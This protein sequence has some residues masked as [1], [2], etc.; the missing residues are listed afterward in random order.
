MIIVPPTGATTPAM[1]AAAAKAEKRV[2]EHLR[3]RGA[4][5]KGGATAYAPESAAAAR[6]LVRLLDRG[7]V[8]EAAEGRYWFDEKAY[9]TGVSA[10]RRAARIIVVVAAAVAALL[11]GVLLLMEK[12]G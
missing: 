7:A 2:V 8:V 4:K 12:G 5:S 1:A 3:M 10:K 6:A 9:E 11:M